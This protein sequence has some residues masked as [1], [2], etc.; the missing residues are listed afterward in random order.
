[1]KSTMCMSTQSGKP[2]SEYH[3]EYEAQD[4]AEYAESKHNL[5]LHPYQCET[6][7]LWHLSPRIRNKSNSDSTGSCSCTDR[8]GYS[9]ELY[10]LKETAKD[11][12]SSLSKEKKFRL[13]VYQ[14]PHGHGWHLTKI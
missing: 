7:G 14:C 12:A 2:L 5:K 6:C 4:G 13:R 10:N 1:M 11:I 3:S 8:H 9:K